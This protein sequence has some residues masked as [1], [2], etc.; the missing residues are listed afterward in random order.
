MLLRVEND[1]PAPGRRRRLLREGAGLV[2]LG[3]QLTTLGGEVTGEA[4][5]DGTF[6]VE[7]RLPSPRRRCNSDA[8]RRPLDL[9][10]VPA[11]V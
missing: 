2:G 11:H 9:G 3:E 8:W 7:A 1:G 5:P 10:S 4:R 6:L